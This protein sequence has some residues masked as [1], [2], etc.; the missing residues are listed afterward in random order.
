MSLYT[1]RSTSSERYNQA[2]VGAFPIHTIS[3]HFPSTPYLPPVQVLGELAADRLNSGTFPPLTDIV[4]RTLESMPDP[5]PAPEPEPVPFPVYESTALPSS[6][7][8]L[9][10]TVVRPSSSSSAVKAEGVDV[11]MLDANADS[12]VD[13]DAGRDAE[14]NVVEDS[15]K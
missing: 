7:T 11:I 6:L 4:P 14:E 12:G 10:S 13:P 2:G 5:E 9:F 3:L 1:D 8:Q 15:C